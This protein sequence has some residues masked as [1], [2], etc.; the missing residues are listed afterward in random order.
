MKRI[1]EKLFGDNGVPSIFAM[2]HERYAGQ[3]EWYSRREKAKI[4][5]RKGN[6]KFEFHVKN[7][8]A[9]KDED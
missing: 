1:D 2:F 9:K 5:G 3:Y 6:V 8:E 7:V 4:K